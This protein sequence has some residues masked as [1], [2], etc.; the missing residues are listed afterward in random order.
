MQPPCSGVALPIELLLAAFACTQRHGK[1]APDT[2]ATYKMPT[3][4][5]WRPARASREKLRVL[6][7]ESPG[8]HE[9]GNLLLV[10]PGLSSEA[11][12]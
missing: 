7:G 3:V 6:P 4:A 12:R 8:F 2:I 10:C 9:A 11:N 5:V 1:R